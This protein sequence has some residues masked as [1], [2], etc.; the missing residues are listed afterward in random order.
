LGCTARIV[1]LAGH[2][3]R[4][5]SGTL[6]ATH[7]MRCRD[8]LVAPLLL[9]FAVMA[10]SAD[11]QAA[12][13]PNLVPVEGWLERLSGN[14]LPGPAPLDGTAAGGPAPGPGPHRWARQVPAAAAPRPRDPAD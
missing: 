5:F 1:S 2:A 6:M 14:Q 13:A 11:A 8:W 4:L 12:P 9:L 7:G 10:V 3:Y